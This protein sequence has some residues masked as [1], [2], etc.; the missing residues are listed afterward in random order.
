MTGRYLD[1]D[2]FSNMCTQEG[3]QQLAGRG[4]REIHR[5][6]VSA[7]STSPDDVSIVQIISYT[8]TRFPHPYD[9]VDLLVRCVYK[10]GQETERRAWFVYIAGNQEMTT[11]VESAHQ[12]LL[13]SACSFDSAPAFVN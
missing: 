4:F 9:R 8:S 6:L 5:S 3:S 13:A 10:G 1:F 7:D 2:K 12:C 11:T